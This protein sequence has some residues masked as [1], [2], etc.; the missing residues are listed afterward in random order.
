[1][2]Q[3]ARDFTRVSFTTRA[4][5]DVNGTTVEGRV[6]DISMNGVFVHSE[7]AVSNGDACRVRI[8]L[9]EQDPLLIHAEGEVVRSRADGFAVH[10]TGLY[11]ES[12]PHL[13]QV[14][15][16]NSESPEPAEHELQQHLGISSNRSKR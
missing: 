7:H 15:L 14:I 12:F 5:V 13:K 10:F 8:F 4:E 6:S 9:G 2:E 11:C 1:M 3:N 16:H